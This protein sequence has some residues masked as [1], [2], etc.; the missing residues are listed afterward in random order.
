MSGKE[1]MPEVALLNLQRMNLSKT[2][3]NDRQMYLAAPPRKQSASK[4]YRDNI[5]AK[6]FGRIALAER[7]SGR[8]S[9]E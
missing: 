7:A 4:A 5:S 6:A 1:T 9:V 8:M 3:S 2:T